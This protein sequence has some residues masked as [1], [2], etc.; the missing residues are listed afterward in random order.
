M[1]QRFRT[2]TLLLSGRDVLD[3]FYPLQSNPSG[4]LTSSPSNS[5]SYVFR[6]SIA[7]G[8]SQQFISFPSSLD[9]SARVIATLGNNLGNNTIP[10]QVS[11]ITGSG[12]WVN[13]ANTIDNSGYYLDA[14]G[15]ISTGTGLATTVIVNN[16]SN[17]YNITGSQFDISGNLRTTGIVY[18]DGFSINV[19]GKF[20][21]YNNDYLSG[22]GI[23]SVVG[24]VNL[25]EQT[26]SL[27]ATNL[28]TSTDRGFYRASVYHTNTV[29]GS[30]G[31]LQTII[32][33]TDDAAAQA[34]SPAPNIVLTSLGAANYGTA[35]IQTSGNSN[36]TYSTIVTLPTGS[37]QYSL[38]ITLEKLL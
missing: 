31:M 19:S 26:G 38:S 11:G 2:N 18:N 35:F 20:T 30:N 4:Y 13:F 22:N 3:I 15:C 10:F 7:S 36:I 25:T 9:D 34:S 24:I 33:W 1:A 14:I 32:G 27:S 28:Y 12:F 17:T 37:P 6:T 23:P 16:T 21:K 29:T 5:G 8:I